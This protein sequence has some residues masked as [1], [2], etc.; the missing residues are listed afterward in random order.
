MGL[1]YGDSSEKQQQC[2][3]SVSSPAASFPAQ[4]LCEV[5]HFR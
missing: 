4:C 5:S 3:Q 2:A 1:P